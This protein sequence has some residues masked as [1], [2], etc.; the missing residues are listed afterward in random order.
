[1]TALSDAQ[2]QKNYRTRKAAKAFSA[3]FLQGAL[4]ASPEDFLEAKEAEFCIKHNVASVSVNQ[5]LINEF[6]QALKDYEE[7]DGLVSVD[8]LLAAWKRAEESDL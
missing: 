6:Y 8:D 5:G 7:E 4:I 3:D 2:N 1:M